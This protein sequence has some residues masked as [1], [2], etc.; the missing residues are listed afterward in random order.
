MN[1]EDQIGR[2]PRVRYAAPADN[3]YRIE[4]TSLDG[5]GGSDYYYRLSFGSPQVTDIRLTVSPDNLALSR[6]Q[7]AVLTVTVSR[8]GDVGDVEVR[9]NG[10]PAGIVASPLTIPRGQSTGILTLTEA[11]DS[12][13]AAGLVSIEGEGASGG[14]K[15]TASA[16]AIA[17]LPRPGEGQPAPRSVD[18]MGAAATE[19]VPLFSLSLEPSQ[20]TIAPGQTVM[21]KV[22]AA[23]KP[24]DNG[25]NPAIALALSNLPPG[26]T[27]ET[28]AIPDKAGEVTIK[29]TA[30]KEAQ[31]VLQNALLTGKIGDNAQPAPALVINVKPK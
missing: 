17:T 14:K 9:V 12:K 28:P 31:P 16:V 4:V 29:L 7:S 6:G 11:A 18:L 13:S 27:A 21:V 24:G 10:L 2:D 23:R 30:A 25:A 3:A 1:P 26:V 8:F 15:L 20:V 22:K 5:K 19:G